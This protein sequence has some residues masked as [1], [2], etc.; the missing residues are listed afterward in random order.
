MKTKKLVAAG[1]AASMLFGTVSGF[2][3]CGGGVHIHELE[4]VEKKAATCTEAGYEAYYRCSGCEKL[5]SDEKGETEITS[6][7]EIAAG[8]K[9]QEVGKKDATCTTEGAAAHYQ[10][11]VC[12]T[13]F[14]DAAGKN[15]I[16]SVTPIPVIAHEIVTVN[17][18]RPTCTEAGY[19][20]HYKCSVCGTL[21]S[22]EEGKTKIDAPTAITAEHRLVPTAKKEATCAEAGYEAYYTCSICNKLFSDD[23]GATEISAPVVIPQ[24]TTHTLGFG[25]TAENVP[26]PVAAGGKLNSKCAVCGHDM[27]EISYDGGF[28]LASAQAKDGVKLNG[29]GTYYIQC[30]GGQKRNS[31]VGFQVNKAGTYK[32]TFTD[33]FADENVVRTLDSLWINTDKF[34]TTPMGKLIIGKKWATTS[35]VAAKVAQFKDKVSA[36]GFEEGT[37]SEVKSITFTFTEQDIPQNGNL[38]IMIGLTHDDMTEGGSGAAPAHTGTYLVKY[39]ALANYNLKETSIFMRRLL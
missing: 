16:T 29:T 27:G 13:L 24:T 38:Y 11:T 14:S 6:P 10:C 8:H 7:E 4:V 34:P 19:E 5:F 3:S 15:A 33:V 32:I 31:Y 17:E 23:A 1:L 12:N 28:T 30:Y 22:D 35:S 26:A 20:E 39:E 25:Y 37:I 9:I 21:F 18:K 2:T 36:E